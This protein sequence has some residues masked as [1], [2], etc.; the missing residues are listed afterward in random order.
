L[1]VGNEKLRIW[2]VEIQELAKQCRNM[3]DEELLRLALD[4]M[5]LT[6]EADAA[7]KSELSQRGIQNGARLSVF[8]EEEQQRKLEESRKPGTFFVFHPYGIGRKR[9]GKAERSYN[10][11]TE[12]EQFRTTVFVLLFWFPLIPTGTFLVERKRGFLPR[13]ITILEKLP[14]DWE[15]VLKVW[16][17]ASATLLAAIWFLKLLPRL[18]YR[19]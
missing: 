10:P 18:L 5:Q 7:L 17:I 9:F 6:P 13:E 1:S 15:Q 3:K 4:T 14:L 19:G 16:V 8:R 12:V 11:E 2:R